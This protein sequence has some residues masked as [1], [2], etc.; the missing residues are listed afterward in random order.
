MTRENNQNDQ[1]KGISG[2]LIL[3]AI[4]IVLT[5]VRLIFFVVTEYP[6]IIKSGAWEQLTTPGSPMYNPF[7]SPVLIFELIF[8]S[9]IILAW[10]YMAFLFFSKK[11]LFPK[12]YV[13][14]AIVS[15]VFVLFDL[16]L[17]KLIFPNQPVL[18]PDI[19]K[20]IIRSAMMLFVWSPYMILSKRV[21]ATFVN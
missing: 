3:I 21:K 18:N 12:W 15:F 11:L 7:F 10:L 14:I 9:L 20:E 17:A 2:W 8:N 6:E 4:G 5:P 1:L 16:L 13:S 19:I